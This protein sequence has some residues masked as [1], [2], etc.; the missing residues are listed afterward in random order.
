[1]RLG[2]LTLYRAGSLTTGAATAAFRRPPRAI[3]EEEK[4]SPADGRLPP[5]MDGKSVHEKGVP[6]RLIARVIL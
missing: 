5:E 1:M 3:H 6:K 2:A 4:D